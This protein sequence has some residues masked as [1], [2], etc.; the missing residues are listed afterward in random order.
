MG[1]ALLRIGAWLAALPYL[2]T[3]ALVLTGSPT[4]SGIAYML[5]IGI[6]L[7]GLMTL[8]V[9]KDTTREVFGRKWPRGLSRAGLV[10]VFA[11]MFVRCCSAGEGETMHMATPA[12][13]VDRI[14]DEQDVALSGMRVLTAGRML[15]DDKDEMPKAMRVAYDQMREEQGD[16][17][18]PF[19]A[20]YLG[21]QRPSA[22]DMLVIEPS[23]AAQA[24]P[25]DAIV[26]LHGYAGNFQLPCWQVSQ[27]MKGLNV[28][29]A[30]PS[31]DFVGVWSTPQGEATLRDVVKVLHDRGVTKIVL[32]GLSNG[33]YGASV[34]APKLKS[35]F[36]GYVFIS[37]VEDDAGSA[38]A[39]VLLIH[40]THDSMASYGE[41]VSY[42]ANHANTQL[43]TLNAGH[44]A[45]LVRSEQTNKA[46][47]DFVVRVTRVGNTERRTARE[48]GAKHG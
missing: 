7:G 10:G 14:V 30:C 12:R 38:G 45:M 15:Q 48:R 23:P 5:A 21:L 33:G 6:L 36:A 1:K 24:P 40:G 28:L 47:R 31:T 25:S 42:R 8:P 43:L 2:L 46:L 41:A 44:F 18:S 34:L 35:T 22:Y 11:I 3:L 27:A 20:T 29:T 16:A 19:V 37:G 39:P 32:A 9:E 4:W 17:P 26:F 13:F